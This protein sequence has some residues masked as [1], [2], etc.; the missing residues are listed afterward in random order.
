MN[1]QSSIL[2]Y[3]FLIKFY[4]PETKQLGSFTLFKEGRKIVQ[5]PEILEQISDIFL[6]KK[7][8]KNILLILNNKLEISHSALTIKSLENFEKSWVDTEKF[9][10]YWVTINNVKY[11]NNFKI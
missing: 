1:Y 4:Y 10:L 11:F 8:L 9:Y 6:E 2:E 7:D 3:F 5:H